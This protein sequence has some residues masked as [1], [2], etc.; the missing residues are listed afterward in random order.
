MNLHHKRT[1]TLVHEPNAEREWN[2]SYYFVFHDRKLNIGGMTRLGFK[3]NKEE[4]ATFLILFLQNGAAG[5]FQSSEKASNELR[6]MNM[7]VGGLSHRRLSDEKWNYSFDGKMITSE[8][9]EDLPSALT[10]PD[11]VKKILNVKFNLHFNPISD[12]YEYSKNMTRESREIGKKSG[13]AHWEQ[14]GKVEGKIQLNE[15]EF[16]IQDTIG[17]RD[18]THGVRD[19]TGIG[20]WLYFVVWFSEVLC[21]NPAAIVTEDG[22]VSTGGFVFRNGENIPIKT[23]R[24]INQEFRN[25]VIPVSSKIQ[26]TDASNRIY[27][28]E[29]RPG[30]I[31]PLP[32]KDSTGRTSI[33]TQSIGNFTLD[34]R[35][36]GYGSY[37]TL[38]KTN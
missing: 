24:I 37:E 13:D 3:P 25:S 21:I 2:E 14:V 27:I 23:I 36:R 19:W 31:V 30:P 7:C 17:Q 15:Q 11:L 38:R 6:K 33:L 10:R 32:F 18:H 16:Y 26:I 8:K 28:L 5:L 9:P 20:N 12:T 1:E 34:D 35:Q 29:G 22:R 4:G